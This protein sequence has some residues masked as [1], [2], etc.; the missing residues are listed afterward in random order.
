MGAGHAQQ[1]G[2]NAPEIQ[3]RFKTDLFAALQAF[4][5]ADSLHIPHRTLY[6]WDSKPQIATC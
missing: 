3:R 1:F 6:A 4:K 2:K 5:Q